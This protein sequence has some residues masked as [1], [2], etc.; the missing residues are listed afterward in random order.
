MIDLHFAEPH[1]VHL[2]WVVAA[3]CAALLAC[4]YRGGR[5]LERF[6]S[7]LMQGRLVSRPA[8][9]RRVTGHV[10]LAASGLFLVLALMRPQSGFHEVQ[11]ARVG[12][13][14][15]LCLDVSR[16][17]LAEDVAP[18]RLGRAKAEIRDLL[19]Y[20]RRDQ[21]GLIAFAGKATVLCPL[22]PDFGFLRLRL[23]ACGPHSVARGG[24]DLGAPI[25]KATEAFRGHA[26]LSRAI[27]LITDGEDHET[28][29]MDAAKAA[30]ER[31]IRII[32]IGFGDEAGSRIIVTDPS[33]GART[34]VL[35]DAEQPVVTRLDGEL[36][37][38]IALETGGAYIPAGTGT[39][40]LKSIY[41]THVAPL[42]RGRL[43]DHSRLLRHERYQWPLLGALLCLLASA[44]VV[45]RPARSGDRAAGAGQAAAALVVLMIAVSP[46]VAQAPT[47]PGAQAGQT[48]PTGPTGPTAPD[49]NDEPIDA[50]AVYNQAVAQ[51]DDGELD[52][53]ESLFTQARDEAGPDGQARYRSTYNLAWVQVRRADALLSET[54]EDPEKSQAALAA[55]RAAAGWF[56]EAVHLQ[57][58]EPAPRENLEIVGRR[59]VAL[60][61]ALAGQDSQEVVA[62][63][64]RLI[65]QQRGLADVLRQTV[66]RVAR[67]AGPVLPDALRDELGALEVEQ[68]HV[69][70]DLEDLADQVRAEADRLARTPE[71]ERAPEQGL[72][73][74]QLE[75]VQS[76]L[77]A[78]GQRVGQTRRHLRGRQASQ[79]CRRAA[80][81][82]GQLKRARDQLRDLVEVLGDVIGDATRLTQQTGAF[83]A[84]GAAALGGAADTVQTVPAWLTREHLDETLATIRARL[85]E[86][87]ARV[88]AGLAGD[89]AQDPDAP[90]TDA[91]AADPRDAHLL[92]ALRQAMPLLHGGRDR[93]EEAAGSLAARRDHE[94]ARAEGEATSLLIKAHEL[95]LDIRGLIEAMYASQTQMA[96]LLR[97]PAEEAEEPPV[98]LAEYLPLLGALQDGNVERAARLGGLIALERSRGDAAAA[99]DGAGPGGTRPPD[100]DAQQAKRQQL[101]LAEQALG[102]V[103]AAFAEVKQDIAAID[104]AG[105]GADSGALIAHV[106]DSVAE[107]EALRRLFF[108]IVEHLRETARRQVAL[109]DDTRDAAGRPE[110]ERKADAVG[111]LV[112]RQGE[113]ATIA[114]RIAESL[115]A[116]AGLEPATGAAPDATGPGAAQAN[117]GARML[118][119]AGHVEQAADAMDRTLGHLRSEPVAL[120]EAMTRQ[121]TAIEQLLEALRRLEP[122]QPEQP[123][124]QEDG[125][126]EQQQQQQ[127]GD[128]QEQGDGAR[129]QSVNINDLLQ[130]VRDRE[131]QRQRRRRP[132]RYAPVDK[133]W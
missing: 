79:A 28:F 90:Q 119:A 112:P 41:D 48:S 127:E 80:L 107:L 72:R 57:A 89:D 115:T 39:L 15:M 40:D 44:T 83:A 77:Y 10:L 54:A 108:S 88:A 45:R 53:A 73:L 42:T 60:A 110:P 105:S 51:L 123:Q 125:Q 114:R 98:P 67:E 59:I 132:Q 102:R 106:A 99:P 116:Q 92:V 118:Q 75:A 50:R 13:Q 31:G 37:S 56:A 74:A 65:E 104:D 103:N 82:L 100:A 34:E 124:E 69:L 97:P 121:Q 81:A 64:D 16:S 70:A 22:T 109:A 84:A 20:V 14:L 25:R 27:V 63:L 76:Y 86:L 85:A 101:E 6:L 29:V 61:D 47:D 11:T 33:T 128:E 120:D 35:D 96:A 1:W 78:A 122:P 129:Q 58:D 46:V 7:T 18:S 94:A 19:A 12:A 17:M 43:A 8:R 111:P 55:L 93:F 62:R 2:T 113:L 68:R 26:D 52:E 49:G 36:L 91:P 24:T 9:W 21:V 5:G 130:S 117:V 71:S 30:A 131:A 23:D 4:D 126:Q 66:D 32:A 38:R 87:V 133:D 95:F 3:L